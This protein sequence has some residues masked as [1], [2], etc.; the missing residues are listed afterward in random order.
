M[1]FLFP[2][3]PWLS[4]TDAMSDDWTDHLVDGGKGILPGDQRKGMSSLFI[5][6]APLGRLLSPTAV[7][8]RPEDA[9]LRSP[10]R[11]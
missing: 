8:W 1:F 3:Q 11:V 10:E 2:P 5:L 9:L 7:S 6:I 4:R